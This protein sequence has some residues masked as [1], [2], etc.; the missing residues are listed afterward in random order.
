MTRDRR[1]A[2]RSLSRQTTLAR[3]ETTFNLPDWFVAT[4]SV[5]AT[6]QISGAATTSFTDGNVRFLT[7]GPT[8]LDVHWD[9]FQSTN[10]SGSP[11]SGNGN[12]GDDDITAS[13]STTL[14]VGVNANQSCRVTAPSTI[15]SQGFV[16][17]TGQTT[18]PAAVFTTSGTGN[19]TI[20]VTGF[21]GSGVTRVTANYAATDAT[22]PV[23]NSINRS[24]TSPTNMTGNVS[25]TVV[26]SESV[27]GVD[28]AD[29]ALATIGLGGSTAS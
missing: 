19:R 8:L 7:N 20:C 16:N 4:Y 3:S 14:T 28:A 29:F 1:G 6:G 15:G 26:F 2:E 5:V 11:R 24:G 21:S 25:W 23:V 18:T 13:E 10:C 9:T 12:T 27:T 17:W 22:G